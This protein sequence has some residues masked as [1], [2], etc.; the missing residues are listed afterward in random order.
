MDSETRLYELTEGYLGRNLS[1][2]ERRELAGMV[3]TGAA[4]HKEFVEQVRLARRLSGYFNQPEAEATWSK[5]AALLDSETP[6]HQ[7][8][9]AD[10]VEARIDAGLRAGA[11]IRRARR[12]RLVAAAAGAAAA[13]ALAI[14]VVTKQG[15]G[16][17]STGRE[18]LASAPAGPA[19]A[20]EPTMTPSSET[21]EAARLG[22]GAA[23][24][25]A[26]P[27][28]Q[29]I[30]RRL[31]ESEGRA[32]EPV[33]LPAVL[34]STVAGDVALLGAAEGGALA[35]RADLLFF[36]AFESL[37]SMARWPIRSWRMRRYLSTRPGVEGNGMRVRFP[38]TGPKAAQRDSAAGRFGPP[39]LAGTVF[40]VA[41][42]Q[43]A[44]GGALDDVH[45]RYY[46]RFDR[47]FDFAAGGGVLPGLCGGQC[48]T[49]RREQSR[50]LGFSVRLGVASDGTVSFDPWLPDARPHA[51]TSWNRK[52]RPGKWHA[53]EL[54]V[55]LNASADSDGLMEGWFD[56]EKVAATSGC[57][58]RE[59]ATVRA[60]GLLF[61][62]SFAPSDLN[63]ESPT[64]GATFDNLVVAPGYIG[65]RQQTGPPPAPQRSP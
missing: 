28:A 58:F 49:R 48:D 22:S 17:P 51:K 1:D 63:V 19:P 23:A 40:R 54:R 42:A 24:Q 30:D 32:P 9:L 61:E 55:K 59:T 41:L 31:A 38:P 33:V 37:P 13:C 20:R 8:R 56:G 12:R 47:A 26:Q 35:S 18:E 5:V 50:K 29:P 52:L 43:S 60:D 39:E 4:L 44:A 34:S 10:A 11:D 57:R 6:E 65:P 3:S 64:M 45:V 27:A 7:R 2:D 21:A 14:V 15:P 25:P 53:I 16:E 62:T 46:V 36:G